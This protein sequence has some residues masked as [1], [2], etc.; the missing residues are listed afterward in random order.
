MFP[1]SHNEKLNVFLGGDSRR[2]LPSLLLAVFFGHSKPK[3]NFKKRKK[4]TRRSSETLKVTTH[5]ENWLI[6]VKNEKRKRLKRQKYQNL[7]SLSVAAS[8][9][10]PITDQYCTFLFLAALSRDA[11]QSLKCSSS[12]FFPSSCFH[13]SP[14]PIQTAAQ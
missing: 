14:T 7:F 3:K 11:V 9:F 13:S 2:L 8:Q 12:L 10:H 5:D 1:G 6:A 4:T